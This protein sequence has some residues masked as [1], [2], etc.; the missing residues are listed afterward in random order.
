M[1][2]GFVFPAG[3]VHTA[4][5]C[6]LAAEAAGWDGYFMWDPIWGLDPWITLTAVAVQ[7]QRIRLGSMITPLSRRRPWTLAGT[8]AALDQISGGR[9][10][11]A[12]G[13]GAIDTGF[14]NFG[15]ET[16][17][18]KRAELLD[19]G[20]D[21]LTGLWRGQPFNYNGKHYQV[22]E[23]D[24]YPPLPPVQQ[25]RIPIW[26][27]GAWPSQKSMTRVMKYDGVLPSKRGEDGQI[28][29]VEG[30]D[31]LE[32]QEYANQHRS[33]HTPFDIVVEG[34]TPGNHP[35]KARD[36][37]SSWAEAGATWWIEALWGT[38]DPEKILERINQGPPG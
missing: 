36:I 32:I 2:F 28:Q 17:R 4:I 31:L 15:E 5:R 25:P 6:G 16:D 26:V 8:L 35:E 13:L 29:Q 9:V 37:L 23:I 22:K 19:E 11:L 30:K 21:I 18:K 10:I 20:L 14:E 34:V 1:K 27:V 33:E 12:V 24:F 38:E 3:D 7:T